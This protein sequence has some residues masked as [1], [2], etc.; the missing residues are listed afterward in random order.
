MAHKDVAITPYCMGLA[1]D[2][3]TYTHSSKAEGR[4]QER[5]YTGINNRDFLLL[6][7]T[8]QVCVCLAFVLTQ[9]PTTLES[10][11]LCQ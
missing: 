2:A 1:P 11:L 7:L 9:F 4:L 6:L 8:L 3:R 5:T 10:L